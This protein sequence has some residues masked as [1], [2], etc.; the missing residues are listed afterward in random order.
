MSFQPP[1][2]RLGAENHCEKIRHPDLRT[3]GFRGF[4]AAQ[5]YFHSF[6]EKPCALSS[7][8]FLRL[9]GC[10]GAAPCVPAF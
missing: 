1:Q 2:R 8:F 7:R 6:D 5:P 4:S 3:V 9:R 10:L